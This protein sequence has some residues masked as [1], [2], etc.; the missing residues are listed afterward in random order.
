MLTK[1]GEISKLLIYIISLVRV[2]WDMVFLLKTIQAIIKGASFFL[3][4]EKVY[5]PGQSPVWFFQLQ[6]ATAVKAI[7]N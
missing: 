2:W 4:T 5:L 7:A 3:A 1:T 6:Y